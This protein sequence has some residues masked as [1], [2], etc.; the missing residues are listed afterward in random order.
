VVSR[1]FPEHG[2]VDLLT[3]QLFNSQPWYDLNLGK[4]TEQQIIEQYHQIHGIDLKTFEWLMRDLKNSLLPLE[5]SLI[6][7]EHV[8]T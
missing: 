2:D 7:L 4:I 5:D 8:S 3:K 1:L 6:L